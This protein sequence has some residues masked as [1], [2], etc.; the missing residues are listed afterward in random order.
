MTGSMNKLIT[1]TI[2]ITPKMYL[3]KMMYIGQNL[4]LPSQTD[5]QTFTRSLKQ[6]LNSRTLE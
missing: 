2:N 6:Q 4:K 3:W 1:F 5:L